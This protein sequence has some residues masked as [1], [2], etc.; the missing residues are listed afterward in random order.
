MCVGGGGGGV[1]GILQYSHFSG[2][3]HFC[4]GEGTTRGGGVKLP[5]TETMSKSVIKC[6]GILASF[7]LCN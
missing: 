2:H 6:T 7:L 1:S 5:L 3:S 4:E